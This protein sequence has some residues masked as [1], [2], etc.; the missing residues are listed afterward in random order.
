MGTKPRLPRTGAFGADQRQAIDQEVYLKLDRALACAFVAYCAAFTCAARPATVSTGPAGEQHG[1]A[2]VAVDATDLDRRIYRVH[3]TLPVGQGPLTL[4]YPQWIPGTYAPTGPLSR[5]A[6]LKFTI[7][8]QPLPWHRDP[9]NVFASKVLIPHGATT[10]TADFQYLARPPA[11][12][13]G[14]RP[15]RASHAHS[16]IARPARIDGSGLRAFVAALVWQLKA[17]R[18]GI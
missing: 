4:F 11:N 10:L 17:G 18:P 9:L 16:S 3:E 13:H 1:I 15:W 6:G 2:T 7:D 8:G 14:P 12:G 5:L